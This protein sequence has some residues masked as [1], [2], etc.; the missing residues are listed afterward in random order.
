M[1]IAAVGL[2]NLLVPSSG[3]PP[4]PLDFAVA[5]VTLSIMIGL[6]VWT[7]GNLKLFCVLIGVTLGYAC[8]LVVGSVSPAN[9]AA[10]EMVPLLAAPHVLDLSWRFEADMIVPFVVGGLA[11]AMGTSANITVSQRMNDAEWVRPDIESNSRGTLA[12]GAVAA[13]AGLLGACGVGTIATNVGVMVA[14]GVTSRRIVFAFGVITTLCAFMPRFSALLAATPQPVVGGAL[15]FSSCF[16]MMNGLQIITGRLIDARKSIVVGLAL[17]AALAVNAYPDLNVFMPPALRSLAASSLVAGT[18][19]GLLLTVIFRLGIRRVVTMEVLPGTA[20]AEPIEAFMLKN[21]ASW[22]ARP[23]VIRRAIFGLTQLTDAIIE[24]CEP[25]GPIAI[26]AHFDEFNLECDVT[27]TG[28]AL[29]FP[30]RRPTNQEIIASD[31]GARRLAGFMLRRNAD[32]ILAER[33]DDNCRV[34]FH[35]NH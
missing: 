32:R 33:Q 13:A 19:V 24:H 21:G 16:T 30:D 10:I 35:F 23:D 29:E 26:E 28:D 17:A 3:V 20:F 8:S 14:T 34:H 7:R 6:N 11:A 27:Y 12:D 9:L 18:L 22:G 1:Q 15:L 2:R 25:R 4:T 31:Q 5:G